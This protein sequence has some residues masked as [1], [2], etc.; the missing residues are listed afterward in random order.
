M[1]IKQSMGIKHH[2]TSVDQRHSKCNRGHTGSAT[3]HKKAG[4]INKGLATG[5]FE[6]IITNF[7]K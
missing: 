6:P 4:K 3:E 2:L 5:E 1:G 7:S